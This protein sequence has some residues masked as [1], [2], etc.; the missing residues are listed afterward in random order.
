MA[1]AT[2]A[3]LA[4]FLQVPSVDTATAELILDIVAVSIDDW[5]GQPLAQQSLSGL[6]LDGTGAAEIVL[7]GFPVNSVASIETLSAD[8]T[9]KL[10]SDGVDFT[11]SASGVVRRRWPHANTGALVVP[12]WPSGPSSI[13]VSYNRGTGTVKSSIKGVNLAA[14]ARMMTNPAGLLSEQIGGMQLRYSA[15]TPGVEFS[16]LEQ[17]ILDRATDPVLA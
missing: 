14:A 9:W 15:K 10:L 3:D 7:P 13:R 5:C 16:A 17:V 6:L 8:G 2:A 12:A 11:W 4:S 1:Y